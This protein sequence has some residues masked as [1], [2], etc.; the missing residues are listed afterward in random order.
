VKTIVVANFPRY[1]SEIWLPILWA[2]AKTYYEKY[3]NNIDQWF[4]YPCK[5]DVFGFDDI[6]LIKQELLI[7][8]P[9]IF[10]ISLYV[11][12][13]RLAH[14]IAKWVKTTWPECLVITGGP[15]QYIKHNTDWF[16][17][18]WYI[19]ASLPSDSYGEI[20]F[21]EILDN[22]T[23]EGVNWDTVSDIR[24]PKGKTRRIAISR[25]SINRESKSNYYF[26]W[27]AFTDQFNEL[28]KFEEYQK[29]KFPNSM[30]LS[31]LETTRGCPY[32]CTY[33]DW[34]GGIATTVLQKSITAVKQDID[35]LTK[36]DLTY[37]YLAD[38]N[39]GIFGERD[40]EIANYIA[41][42]KLQNAAQFKIG[43]GGF[44]KTVNRLS[45]IR[46]I[47]EIDIE[48]NLSNS[49]ELKLS[50]QTLD[51]QILDNIDRKN[52]SLE[53][54][55]EVFQP[56]AKNNKLPLYVEIIMGLPGMTLD[57]FYYELNVF[58]KFNLAV[59]WYE[60]ILLPESPAYSINYRIKWGIATVV[61]HNGW[62]RPESH[63]LHEIVIECNSY[64]N[65][66]YLEMLLSASLYNLLIQG[67]F[68]NKTINWIVLRY[69]KS[70]GDIVK[71]IYQN[72]F[73]GTDY[74]S[75]VLNQ[76]NQI[77]S[78]SELD[79]TFNICNEKIYG[80]YYFV[81]LA[82][83]DQLFVKQ[84]S[85]YLT[86]YYN[87]PVELTT[88]DNSMHL[89]VSKLGKTIRNGLFFINF[90]NSEL[91]IHKLILMYQLFQNTGHIM[92]GNKKILGLLTIND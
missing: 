83:L 14:K 18:H 81:A 15:H 66:D 13:Y 11:W 82:F 51:P 71:N 17:K 41:Q 31:I 10:A 60:W 44:A 45:Y 54:Q 86:E 67:G 25:K 75:N 92:Q 55:L 68:F 42:C 5:L 53:Q 78:N 56:I 21:K 16:Q 7:A 1:S 65:L 38:A 87:V 90:K 59:Q 88:H 28:K 63:A 62:S 9:S 36:F 89:D 72:F 47:V 84:V 48:H 49:K 3:G 61:K 30:L 20:C 2:Q 76:W 91:T 57:K 50:L 73:K 8:K 79:C 33:C 39:F 29:E 26:D 34:G 58:G 74:Y 40:V 6:E 19:D 69:N 85:S 64:T 80:G 32:G 37:L 46:K 4:W 23:L 43:Y 70:Y 52:I 24:Y 35:S 12:N 77:L 22:Y 27:S